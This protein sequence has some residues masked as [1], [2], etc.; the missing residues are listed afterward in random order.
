MNDEVKDPFSS[1]GRLF[2]N[3]FRVP[4]SLFL[5]LVEMAEELG[6]EKRPKDCCG[7]SSIPLELK[8]LGTLRVLGR[9]TCFDGIQELTGGS[10]EV[11]RGFSMNFVRNLLKDFTIHIFILQ[12]MQKK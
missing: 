3:R 1:K 9:A 10:R 8:I 7:R 2:R 12:R 4:F 5:K 6:F 11:H